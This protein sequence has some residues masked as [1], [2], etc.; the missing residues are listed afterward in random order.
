M[1]PPELHRALAQMPSR[2]AQILIFRCV[3]GRAPADCAALYG[4]GL[5]QWEVLQLEAARA[6]AGQT[7]PLADAERA[8]LGRRLAAQ[9]DAPEPVEADA[10]VDALTGLLRSLRSNGPELQRLLLEAERAGA[11]SPARAREAWLRRLAVVVILAVSLF[12]WLRERNKPA[13]QIP[14]PRLEVR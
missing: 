4:V 2:S 1:T 13:P 12:V 5:P 3:E 7:L 9:L 6:L 8:N 14:L 10:E 11:A